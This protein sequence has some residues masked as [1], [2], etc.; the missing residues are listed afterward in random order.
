MKIIL[1]CSLLELSEEE[2]DEVFDS[3][4]EH[5]VYCRDTNGELWQVLDLRVQDA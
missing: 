1:D 5:E 2:Q 4:H 3:C